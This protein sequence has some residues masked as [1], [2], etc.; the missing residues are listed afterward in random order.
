MTSN[1]KNRW[2]ALALATTMT[3]TTVS[4]P[5]V[6]AA[7]SVKIE[8]IKEVVESS[9]TAESTSTVENSSIVESSSTAGSSSAVETD[10]I[11]SDYQESTIIEFA[12]WN[13]KSVWKDGFEDIITSSNGNV[14]KYWKNELVPSNWNSIWVAKAPS[15]P[16][17]M[18]FEVATDIKTEG[19]NSVHLHSKDS[20][21]RLAVIATFS[22]IDYSK[23]YILQMKI[24]H[25]D[26]AGTGFYA[27]AQV[28]EKG[29]KALAI[30]SKIKGTSD[31]TTYQILLKDLA[32]TAGDNSGFMKL[33]LFAEYMTGDVWIDQIEIVEDYTLSINQSSAVIKEGQSLQLSVQS[34][35]ES[36]DL[37]KIQWLSSNPNIASVDASGKVIGLD[38]GTTEIVAKIDDSHFAVCKVSVS[39]PDKEE[40]YY[41]AMREKWTER[42]TGNSYWAG[43][44][45][46]EE[47]KKILSE[48]D[49]QVDE[50][51]KV[52]VIENAEQ[53]FTDLELVAPS[54]PNSTNSDD[55][56]DF[57]TAMQRIHTMA[58]A[59]ASKG[60]K[61]YQDERLKTKI[62][63]AMDWFY[64]KCYN[65]KLDNK[66]M[67]GNW[68][69]WWIGIPQNLAGTV[70]LMR[71]VM[72]TE[73]LEKE[74]TTLARFNEDPSYAYKVKGAGGGKLEMVSGN[75][76]DTSLV[77]VLRGV[78]AG[79][80]TAIANGMKYFGE[81]ARVVTK[82]EG[83]YP[84]GSFIQHTNLAYTGGYGSTLLNGVEKLLYLTNGTAW[85]V[86]EQQ[87]QVIYDWIWD[88]IRPLY[89]KGAMFDMVS[90]RGIA[91]PSRTDYT[92]GRGILSA[93]VLLAQSAPHEVKS[94]LESFAKAQ[95]QYAVTYM[96]KEQYY[97]G[98]NSAA[99][100]AAL[101]IVHNE[102]IQPIDNINY[103]KAL[104]AMDK[105]VAHSERFSFGISMASSRTGRFEYGNHENKTG[106][107]QSDGAT[108]M[109]NGD[110]AQ[111]ADNYWNTVDPHRL[112]GITTD[113]SQWPLKDWANYTGNANYVGGATLGQ[114][115]AFA[116]N[117]KNYT[118]A[119][120]PN[121]TAKKT[122]FVFDDEILALG[123]GIQGIDPTR[124]T[125]TIIENKKVK[126]DASN[127]LL[128]DG[129]SYN[130]QN[131]VQSVEQDIQWA[132]LEG[133]TTQDSMGYYFPTG[134]DVTVKKEVRTGSWKDINGSNGV[135]DATVTKNYVSLAVEHGQLVNAK[136]SF[137][138][139]N[140]DYVLLP[141]KS[142]EEVKQ[143]AQNPDIEVLANGAYVQA[144]RDNRSNVSSYVFWEQSKNRSVR[145]GNVE[146][147]YGSVIVKDNPESNQMEIA[148]SSPLQNKDKV[149]V[150]I[151]GNQMQLVQAQ[152]GISV[153]VDK[154]GAIITV[155]TKGDFGQS[156]TLTLSY[157]DQSP[158]LL[159]SYE[160]V[161]DS[162]RDGLT[163]NQM[164]NKQDE[165]YLSMMQSYDKA[166][167]EAWDGLITA[168]NRTTLWKDLNM[169]IDY[170]NKGNNN[171]DSA[172]FR[173][174][175]ERLRAMALAYAS[176]GSQY[177]KN[178]A[179]FKDLVSAL[180]YVLQNYPTNLQDKVYGNWWTWTIGVPKDLVEIAIL[181]YNDLQPELVQD[182]YT[183]VD[184]VLP[185]TE[186]CWMRSSRPYL[187]TSTAA[188]TMDMGVI[189]ALN[190]A[191]GNNS[192]GLYMASDALPLMMK[193]VTKG[194]GFYA[195]GSFK[196]HG[197]MAYT[198][199]YGA[200]ALRGVAK[201]ASLTTGTPWECTEADPNMV[202]EWILEGFRPLFA[203]GAMMEMVVGRQ[204]SRYNRN[205]ITTA[206][207]IM[208]AILSLAKN[209]PPQYKDEI[210]SFAKTQAK[211]GIQYDPN[212]YYGGRLSFNSLITLKQLLADE[213][214]P[215]YRP[216][217]VKIFGQMD[218]ATV[219][220][221]E[222]GLGISMYSSRTGNAECG[223]SENFK[224]W[225]TSDGATFLYNGD[226]AQFA[227]EYWPTVDMTRLPGITTNHVTGDLGNFS[228]HSSS[229]DWVGGSRAGEKFASI[230]MDFE[231][232]FSD[233]TAKKSW[234]AFGDQIIAL[235]AGIT[236]TQGDYTETIVENRKIKEDGSNRILVDG[237]EMVPNIGD[238]NA[239][240]ANWAWLEANEQGSSIGYYFPEQAQLTL[241]RQ[242]NTGKWQDINTSANMTN[243]E[244]AKE[245]SH[246]YATMA[247]EHGVQL[248]QEKYSYVLLPGK[249]E[250]QMQEYTKQNGIQILSN[251]DALQAVADTEQGAMGFNFWQAGEIELVTAKAPVTPGITKVSVDVPASVTIYNQNGQLEIGVSDPTQKATA[252]TVR[253]EG[254]N[255]QLGELAQGVTAQTDANGITITVNTQDAYGA[256]FTANIEDKAETTQAVMD[257]TQEFVQ[258]PLTT[259]NLA[260][261]VALLEQMRA[262]DSEL[263]GVEN[264]Q[265]YSRLIAQM[266]TLVAD[267]QTVN[268]VVQ[269]LESV[270]QVT[271]ENAAQVAQWLASYDQLTSEQKQLLTQ[272]QKE[273]ANHAR[274]LLEQ[275]NNNTQ[276]PPVPPVEPEKPEQPNKPVLPEQP[277]V[278][279]QEEYW[280]SVLASLQATAKGGKV[281]SDCSIASYVPGYILTVVKDGGKTLVLTYKGT[282][283][284][285]TPSSLAKVNTSHNYTIS[286]LIALLVKTSGSGSV[287]IKKTYG[288]QMQEQVTAPTI[289]QQDKNTA[290]NQETTKLPQQ[291][292]LSQPEENTQNNPSGLIA[293]LVAVGGATAGVIT[294]AVKELLRRKKINK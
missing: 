38:L 98:M 237:Q 106:W 76:A 168:E 241:T 91:R 153:E 44:T 114:Y 272:Q 191:V 134:A 230:G 240:T 204:I 229:K 186:Y 74:A 203:Q 69:H 30:G 208:D 81:I 47:Y 207:Y 276:I 143:Y 58:K 122:W 232:Q 52:L 107:H 226:Q 108:Y 244:T 249:T 211:L 156:H 95:M 50:I 115:G 7:D 86:S 113:H 234:F 173:T 270:T 288:G 291:P 187:Y 263:V 129:K 224:G 54:N 228:A 227:H 174:A 284:T 26:V 148:I 199:G 63:H 254:Q 218:K 222:F 21:G 265:L 43:E 87:L 19:K 64:T 79:D 24:K 25:Q 171:N 292:N 96:G 268:T 39:D 235:G 159:A 102:A 83:I 27:R 31:W 269:A 59:W 271:A 257:Q 212:I 56:V 183:Y 3:A 289:P 175:T 277:A 248:T 13:P 157:A 144:A 258:S 55:S 128:I 146:S 278:D 217:F 84:D 149:Q 36:I 259:E 49:A 185:A 125:E 16:E 176:E 53:L 94:K 67:F 283:L 198:G 194:D 131:N 246:N 116:M 161:R 77:S 196:Q 65:E 142:A 256:T 242:K 111:Y 164:P 141:G 88:G 145:V 29:N 4:A 85:Q 120:N 118:A 1:W 281:S 233:L 147:D 138:Y 35:D 238:K 70:I 23:N 15:S 6:Y 202:Y 22:G 264:A 214:I 28:G 260:Q 152:P 197:T 184:T 133:N 105:A 166:A 139:E 5:I 261:A 72:S 273:I 68:Y 160:K 18:Y 209:A 280:F 97:G 247:I 200:D 213:S 293:W 75:L 182:I 46:S 170:I 130:T 216:E 165:Q 2:L 109:Y 40:I 62:L 32:Q 205:D 132:W 124:T 181:L 9:S 290:P 101:A 282:V 151:Y 48:Q 41:K 287:V 93:V 252:V 92:T 57:A 71:D 294:L 14:T 80:G 60:S 140:Y 190:G 188:N 104:G 279:P 255:L 192:M 126:D 219:Q 90:G 137:Q 42:L 236:G 136:N 262:L 121:L 243:E 8:E 135:S 266:E 110:P 99:M 169:T 286:D 189:T 167:K 45:T 285:L 172:D 73:L 178:E 245:L 61:Y 253:L 163:G 51:L 17:Q 20:A 206:R 100:M 220:T 158:E 215:E 34:S 78:A 250:Q 274:A 154:Y 177:Y 221:P 89:A 112:A 123:A 225:Y 117:F 210:L 195:D 267:M 155:D 12:E 193:Y 119:E 103:A 275:Y 251:T 82:G 239:V 66:A 231:A 162:Y 37:S 127:Q 180:E 33:E 150:R 11:F 10:S 201:I 179:L 223:N